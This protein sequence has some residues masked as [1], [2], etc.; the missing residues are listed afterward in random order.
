MAI[1]N[2]RLIRQKSNGEAFIQVAS[3]GFEKFSVDDSARALEQYGSNDLPFYQLNEKTGKTNAMKVKIALIGDFK[4]LL[5][6]RHKDGE[7]LI[8]LKD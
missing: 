6:L 3:T 7:R 1:A 2:N 5:L 4:N 8:Q